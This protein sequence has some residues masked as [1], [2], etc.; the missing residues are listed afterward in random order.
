MTATVL[1][2]QI[3]IINQASHHKDIWAHEGTPPCISNF[4]T[5][6]RHEIKALKLAPGI[7]WI[8][9]RVDLRA[10]LANSDC[11]LSWLLMITVSLT[12]C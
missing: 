5:R 7:H 9:G 8:G 6:C 1:L 2:C 11:E 4:S 12:S 3:F 10:I